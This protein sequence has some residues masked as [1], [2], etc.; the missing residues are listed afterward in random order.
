MAAATQLTSAGPATSRHGNP[1]WARVTSKAEEELEPHHSLFPEVDAHRGDELGVELVVGVA[2]EEGG[3][4][5]AG[6]AQRQQLDQVVVIPISHSG[7]RKKPEREKERERV[8]KR[9]REREGSRLS[10]KPREPP[11][12]EITGESKEE[13]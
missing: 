12:G 3:L 6:V 5:H 4:P 11:E 8:R 9:E 10:A 13:N 2:V 1:A 7:D